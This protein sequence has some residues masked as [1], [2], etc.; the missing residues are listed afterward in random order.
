MGLLE[1]RLGKDTVENAVLHGNYRQ[2]RDAVKEALGG[3]E[4]QTF[5]FLTLMRRVGSDAE[6]R[7]ADPAA[8]ERVKAMLA[9]KPGM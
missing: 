2:F 3:S 9:A 6:G 7:V 4:E 5:E 1:A 8:L